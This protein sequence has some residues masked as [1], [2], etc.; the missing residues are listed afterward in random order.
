MNSGG[1]C[2]YNVLALARHT[3]RFSRADLRL[4]NC[5]PRDKEEGIQTVV[6]ELGGKLT[7]HVCNRMYNV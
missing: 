2:K 7:Y 1:V 4:V 6:V 5:R 3:S